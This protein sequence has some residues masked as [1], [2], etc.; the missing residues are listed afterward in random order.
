MYR[1]SL[2]SMF[3][4]WVL[5][6][7]HS[8]SELTF[9]FREPYQVLG[10]H[11]QNLASSST[12]LMT[13]FVVDAQMI[14]DTERFKMDLVGGLERTLHG[15]VKPSMHLSHTCSWHIHRCSL[16]ASDNA[17]L[18]TASLHDPRSSATGQRCSRRSSQEDGTQAL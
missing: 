9:G 5:M 15:K 11:L 17:M 18:Y 10:A 8:L 7:S 2:Y 12:R 4:V 16:L 3:P 14:Q 13:I 6:L 1:N